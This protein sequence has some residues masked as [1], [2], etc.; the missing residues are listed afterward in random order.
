MS[1]VKNKQLSSKI[2]TIISEVIEQEVQNEK[3]NQASVID[4]V[5]SGDN[6]IAI[7]YVEF[8]NDREESFNELVKVTPFIKRRLASSINTRRC[9]EIE[10]RLDD[11]FEEAQKIE[12]VL[13]SIKE[14]S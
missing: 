12:K 11:K 7:I 8:Y 2:H 3:A 5:L 1:S 14:N 13:E 10:F 4:V 6:S 9:P